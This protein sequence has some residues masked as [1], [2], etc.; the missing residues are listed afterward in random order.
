[1]N[2]GSEDGPTPPPSLSPKG[3][4]KK[5]AAGRAAARP[6]PTGRSA[7]P[8]FRGAINWQ[9]ARRFNLDCA[10]MSAL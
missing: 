10:D 1:M 3:E 4:R 5:A 6:R 2:R 7:L 8:E 9:G